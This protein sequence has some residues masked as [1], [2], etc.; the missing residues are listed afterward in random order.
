MFRLFLAL[1]VAP[2]LAS[3]TRGLIQTPSYVGLQAYEFAE[4]A[5]RASLPIYL[6]ALPLGIAAFGVAWSVGRIGLLSA[7]VTGAA[8]AAIFFIGPL[9]GI[10]AD[11]K[12]NDWYKTKVLV[13]AGAEVLFG[14]C[15]GTIAWLLGV[16]RNSAL[17]TRRKKS[18]E[19]TASAA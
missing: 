12:L 16:W 19:H 15:V 11:P 18:R 4:G 10:V 2:F 9:S 8:I 7:V 17:W 3:A 6:F 5:L 14:A 1:L 13:E